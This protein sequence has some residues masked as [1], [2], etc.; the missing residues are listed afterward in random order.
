MT[1]PPCAIEWAVR[2]GV[3]RQ[4]DAV[5]PRLVPAS[6]VDYPGWP[7]PSAHPT[8][9]GLHLI[10]RALPEIPLGLVEVVDG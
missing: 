2:A 8:R 5:L 9:K 4:P 1:E 7:I 6:P 3:M 10:R